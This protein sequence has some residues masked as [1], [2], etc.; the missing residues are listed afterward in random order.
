MFKAVGVPPI[1]IAL[2]LLIGVR[3]IITA[4][5]GAFTLFLALLF[6]FP[7]FATIAALYEGERVSNLWFIVAL[8]LFCFPISALMSMYGATLV[9][10]VLRRSPVLV[11]DGAGLT[12]TRTRSRFLWCDVS[13]ATVKYS[14][15][16]AVAIA[17]AFHKPIDASQNPF[18]PGAIQTFWR[19]RRPDELCISIFWLDIDSYT[20]GNVITALVRRAGGTVP[21][22][23]PRNAW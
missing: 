6:S 15:V 11:I 9:H 19:R 7:I 8:V 21:E 3:R 18:P 23:G 13:M 12:D 16:G 20:V 14:R 1:P 4:L 10:D 5:L 2:P 22:G 17:F